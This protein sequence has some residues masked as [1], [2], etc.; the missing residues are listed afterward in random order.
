MKR[1]V[2]PTLM[3]GLLG[4]FG[5]MSCCPAHVI[6]GETLHRQAALSA[7][8]E[9]SA[10]D[11]S[12]HDDPDREKDAGEA[13][14][15][16]EPAAKDKAKKQ[17]DDEASAQ[18]DA[19][20]D[21]KKDSEKDSEKDGNEQAEVVK[22]DGVFE[23]VR[24]WELV[25]DRDQIQTLEVERILPHGDRVTKG[26]TVVWFD[27]EAVDRQL[28]NA[29]TEMQLAELA[30]DDDQFAYEQFLK[31]QEFDR[32]AAERTRDQAR[33]DYDNYVKVDR[34]QTIE[35]AEF[36]LKNSRYYLA[37]AQEELTQL[38][39]MYEED[40]LTEESEEIVLKR[41]KQAVESAEFNLEKAE[42]RTERMISQTVPLQDATHEDAL[43]K[44]EMAYAK[45]TR[46]LTSAKKQRDLKRKQAARELAKKSEDLQTLREQ[47]K[48]I[49]M[50]APGDGIVLYGQL[51]RG[52]LGSKP[53]TIEVGS[54]ISQK[55][56]V[57][58][59][60]NPNRLRVRVE[61]SESQLAT[62]VADAKCVI[63]PVSQ[64]DLSFDGVVTRV[65]GVPFAAKKF[66]A[67][68]KIK[69]KVDD[70]IVP[71][72]TCSVEFTK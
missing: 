12:T 16:A 26:Q 33:Q 52:A 30:A 1:F 71:A 46:N 53:S 17:A 42:V 37:N 20:K 68:I 62:V 15:E 44:A 7:H 43:A 6:A 25:H 18:K 63:K 51:T 11:K 64:P 67:E 39:Q 10:E 29:E 40:D 14:P 66:D 45:T 57:A 13:S 2:Y 38:T 59:I 47:R 32:E 3:V 35:S 50:K 24:S 9:E 19:E 21:A 4:A 61:L 28:D 31:T 56:V 48:A 58:T 8:D 55:Q 60:V 69:G 41:A 34:E 27:S 70:A 54:K 49:V 22:V 65:A 5:A 72:M 36:S 23:A